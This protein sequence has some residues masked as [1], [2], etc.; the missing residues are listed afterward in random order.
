MAGGLA[1]RSDLIRPNIGGPVDLIPRPAVIRQ[2]LVEHV[3][4]GTAGEVFGVVGA[5]REVNGN[6]RLTS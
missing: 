2:Q 3:L 6:P 1:S 5:D 4:R